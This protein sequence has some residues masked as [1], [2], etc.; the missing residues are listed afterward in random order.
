M[1][2]FGNTRSTGVRMPVKNGWRSADREIRA[3]EQC[4]PNA[5]YGGNV[6]RYQYNERH[7]PWKVVKTR[8]ALDATVGT[9]TDTTAT[10]D[11]EIP[12]SLLPTPYSTYINTG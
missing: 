12:P 2:S 4:R 11:I 9:L 5:G 7:G 1:A 3:I 6:R 8:L 10:M